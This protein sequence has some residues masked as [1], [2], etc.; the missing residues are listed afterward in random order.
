MNFN[1]KLLELKIKEKYG[2]QEKLANAMGI[3]RTTLNLKITGKT[4]FTTTELRKM[5]NLLEIDP[6]KIWDYFFTA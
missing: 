1:S 5:V 4:D 3:S 6:N 2:I